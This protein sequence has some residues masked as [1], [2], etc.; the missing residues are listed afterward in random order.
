MGN[1]KST[2]LKELYSK[3]KI[4]VLQSENEKL[5]GSFKVIKVDS[6]K[7]ELFILKVLDPRIYDQYSDINEFVKKLSQPCPA[8]ADF[9]FIN[10]N[11]Q[12]KELYDLLFEYGPTI[13]T[14]SVGEKELWGFISQIVEALG[15]MEENQ[16]HYPILAKKYVLKF[17]KDK[18]KL[19]NPYCFPDFIKEVLQIYLNP[20]NPISSRK[21]YHKLQISRN[22]KEFGILLVTL[23]ANASEYQL[24]TDVAYTTKTIDS[25]GTKFSKNFIGL[26]KQILVS[27]SPPKTIQELKAFIQSNKPGGNEG[28]RLFSGFRGGNKNDTSFTSKDLS[29]SKISDKEKLDE[30]KPEISIENGKKVPLSPNTK[31]LRIFGDKKPADPLKHR[32]ITPTKTTTISAQ[33]KEPEKPK[34]EPKKE[35]EPL[36]VKT[37][38]PKVPT[39][40]KR[41][42]KKAEKKEV[43][44]ENF[45]TFGDRKDSKSS[46]TNGK[47]NDG[48]VA[49]NDKAVV[50]EKNFQTEPKDLPTI[51][52]PNSA[53]IPQIPASKE[54]FFK[55][56]QDIIEGKRMSVNT[57]PLFT[58]TQRL[59]FEFVNNTPSSVKNINEYLQTHDKNIQEQMVSSM[60][61]FEDDLSKNPFFDD[62]NFVFKKNPKPEDL[63]K[64][65]TNDQVPVKQPAS[66]TPEKAQPAKAV[67][68][69][70]KI[71]EPKPKVEEPKPKL[72][73]SHQPPKPENPPQPVKQPPQQAR[74]VKKVL[75]KWNIN[76]NRHIKF[77]EYDDGTIEEVKDENAENKQKNANDQQQNGVKATEDKPS[78]MLR[79]DIGKPNPPLPPTN[80]FDPKTS[81]QMNFILIPD[82]DQPAFLLF[83][84]RPNNPNPKFI[85]IATVVN[86][87]HPACPS[88]Y[89]NV[90]EEKRPIVYSNAKSVNEL[91]PNNKPNQDFLK[92]PSTGN[93]G[94]QERSLTPTSL[95]R[96]NAR[97]IRKN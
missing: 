45:A 65:P 23:V 84:S 78:H 21:K 51:K 10:S 72:E 39:L 60:N 85:D 71:E 29:T 90:E 82:T 36:P 52:P 18:I 37:S 40:Y 12:N 43:N 58:E 96:D 93:L 61:F 44:L 14:S 77:I 49:L 95:A 75:L 74:I 13:D 41:D 16:L 1:T 54:S 8:I 56:S 80:A 55:Q 25:L 6:F 66:P 92:F 73:E 24:K 59:N 3:N 4:E 57:V 46:D 35:E 87:G 53:N 42:P 2:K 19:L 31:G 64:N 70:P 9:F 91:P 50:D 76:E 28:S 68:P 27:Q 33:K 38:N 11:A 89:H 63:T 83:R 47:L 67:E 88:V 48:S 7:D 81:T 17:A 69:K 15:F 34:E 86:K 62:S 26:L 22:I 32:A 20:M 79:Y 94:G 5:V 97:I 30:S